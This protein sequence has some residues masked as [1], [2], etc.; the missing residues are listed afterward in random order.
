MLKKFLFLFI[1]LPQFIFAQK[2]EI[3]SLLT[4]L[5]NYEKNDSIKVELLNNISKYYDLRSN[6]SCL[7]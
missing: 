3:D 5:K 7:Y 2:N 4:K 1:I 6:D